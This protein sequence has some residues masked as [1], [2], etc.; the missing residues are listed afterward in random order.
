MFVNKYPS[1]LPF[2]YASEYCCGVIPK[3]IL[4]DRK[5]GN[6]IVHKEEDYTIFFKENTPE[7]IKQR[8]IKDYAKYY[9]EQRRKM[10]GNF[11]D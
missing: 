11:F 9:K 1:E 5:S 4:D 10:F 6:C 3:G 8:F 2:A 7:D